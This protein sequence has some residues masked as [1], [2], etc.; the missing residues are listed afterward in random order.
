MAVTDRITGKY[1]RVYL[2]NGGGSNQI[3]DIFNW[4][5]EIGAEMLPCSIKNESFERYAVGVGTGRIRAERY[6]T[7]KATMSQNI[8]TTIQNGQQV[9]FVLWLVNASATYSTISGQ[10]YISRAEVSAPHAKATDAIEITMDGG[11]T[12]TGI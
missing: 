1:G 8:P 4:Q 7:T 10:G 9:Q 11:P 2:D 12:P 6:I 3:L 5:W